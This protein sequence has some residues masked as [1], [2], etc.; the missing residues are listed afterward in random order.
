MKEY[1][2]DTISQRVHDLYWLEDVNCAVTTLIILSEIF[3][4]P[5]HSQVLSSACGMHGAGKFGAQCGLVEGALMFIGILGKN[6]GLNQEEM[7]KLCYDYASL[8]RKVFGS[9]LL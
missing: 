6:N 8:F 1:T 9:L 4:I 3:D 5:V 7:E 2:L